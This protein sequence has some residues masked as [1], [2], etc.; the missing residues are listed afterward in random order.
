MPAAPGPHT[1]WRSLPLFCALHRAEKTRRASRPL[2]TRPPL[3]LHS[4]AL[5]AAHAPRAATARKSQ[6]SRRL[7]SRALRMSQWRK[8]HSRRRISL[9]AWRSCMPRTQRK[10][11]RILRIKH[12]AAPGYASQRVSSAVFRSAPPA[13]F[14]RR[15]RLASY[16]QANS[17]HRTPNARIIS[18]K[19]LADACACWHH[20]DRAIGGAL[21]CAPASPH[22][23]RAA[24]GK[25]A[26]DGMRAGAKQQAKIRSSAASVANIRRM[27]D[28]W[29]AGQHHFSVA[30]REISQ[31]AKT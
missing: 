9:C 28:A 6:R 15:R 1:G 2:H 20:R 29:R 3:V 5:R 12:R 7:P 26:G 8:R 30:H 25:P 11:W 13:L 17:A 23:A 22:L 24:W 19:R 18:G 31:L 27:D 14:V 16:R 10:I 4:F 21:N